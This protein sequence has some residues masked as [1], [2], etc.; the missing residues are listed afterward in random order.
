[1]RLSPVVVLVLVLAGGSVGGVYGLLLAIPLAA[2]AKVV[3]SEFLHPKLEAWAQ[4]ASVS[5]TINEVDLGQRHTIKEYFAVDCGRL[6]QEW[7]TNQFLKS[8]FRI[9]YRRN[10]S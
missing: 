9:S 10:F 8:S 4:E 7:Y 3:F 6:R 2:C 1:M 5:S